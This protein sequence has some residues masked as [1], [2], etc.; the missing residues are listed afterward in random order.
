MTD[1]AVMVDRI[2]TLFLGG[3][4]LV[5]AATGEIITA[6]ELGGATTHCRCV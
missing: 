1:N 6:E 3:P 2:G 4:H 5:R